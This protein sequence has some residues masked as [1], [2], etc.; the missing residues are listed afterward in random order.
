MTLAIRIATPEDV[1]ILFAIRTSVRENHMT[2]EELAAH[3]ITP[4]II[5]E[6]LRTTGRAFIGSIDGVDAGI[7]IADSLTRNIVALFVLPDREGLGLG[8]IL[9]AEAE[10][11]LCA[12]GAGDA[13]LEAGA[14]SGIRA[15][16]FYAHCGW[17]RDGTM[18]DG[19]V[20]FVKTQAELAASRVP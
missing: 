5:A 15:H 11:F 12:S 18:P 19:Q 3:G 6:L 14:I 10:A 8:R 7:A 17:R 2:R 9:L 13:W 4:D 1:P 16:G 20:R